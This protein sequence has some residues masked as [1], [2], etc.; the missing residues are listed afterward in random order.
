MENSSINSFQK[1]MNTL[2]GERDRNRGI[3]K[4][5]LWL[6]TE[7]GELIDAFLKKERKAIEEE[8]ADVFAWLCSVCNLLEIK[9]D[10][11]SWKKYANI[12]PKCKKSPCECEII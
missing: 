4:T 1:L 7:N 8:I 11:V 9:L 10:E 12:C 6:Q 5:L 3:E 2:Y